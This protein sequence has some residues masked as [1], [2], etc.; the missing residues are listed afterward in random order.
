[1]WVDC[2]HGRTEGTFD[3]YAQ[4]EP[5]LRVARKKLDAM[6][7]TPWKAK[8]VIQKI[9]GNMRL[10]TDWQYAAGE[11]KGPA[12]RAAFEAWLE[13]KPLSHRRVY[14]SPGTVVQFVLTKDEL[15]E[16]EKGR[17]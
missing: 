14:H 8:E 10:N 15:E 2:E 11:L 1:M 16:A 3:T 13:T 7:I 5:R 4:V 17:Q 12:A 6:E 9:F